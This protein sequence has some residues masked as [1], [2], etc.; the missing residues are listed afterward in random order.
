MSPTGKEQTTWTVTEESLQGRCESIYQ[1][2]QIPEYFIKENPELVPLPSKC[3]PNPRDRLYFEIIRT[4][5]LRSCQSL[6]Q[7][8]Y[9]KP[10]HINTMDNEESSTIVPSRTSVTRS[11]VCGSVTPRSS[12]ASGLTQTLKASGIVVQRILNENEQNENLMGFNTDN[13]VTGTKQ[14]LMIRNIEDSGSVPLI[15]HPMK[16]HDLMF[17]YDAKM[18]TFH[19]ARS[20][21]G[22]DEGLKIGRIGNSG[23]GLESEILSRIRPKDHLS[24]PYG[25]RSSR[26]SMDKN[27]QVKKLLTEVTEEI[28]KSEKSRVTEDANK[29]NINLKLLSAARG[30][31]MYARPQEIKQLWDEVGRLNSPSDNKAVMKNFFIDTVGMAG[32]PASI[33]FIADL[34]EGDEL[35]HGQIFNFLMWMPHNIIYPTTQLLEKLYYTV[36]SEKIQRHNTT[37]GNIAITSFTQLLQQACVSEERNIVYPTF[38]TGEFCN[39]NSRIVKN[40][41][42]P[43]LLGELA[44]ARNSNERNVY[45]VA[46]GALEHADSIRKL[47]PYVSGDLTTQVGQRVTTLN[48]LM[49]IYSLTNIGSLQPNI[50]I[51]SLMA[52]FSNPTEST[53]IRIAAFNCILKANPSTSVFERIASVTQEE[54]YIGYELLKTINIA[55]YTL[56]HE[57]PNEG[58]QAADIELIQKARV[59]FRMIRKV[60]GILPTTGTIYTTKFL[61]KLGVGYD[62]FISF[63]AS[64]TSVLP[65]SMYTEI[66]YVLDKISISPLRMG[67]RVSGSEHLYGK[68][69]EMQQFGFQYFQ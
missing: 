43:Y 20:G 40:K 68:L 22:F 15:S 37:L 49:A 28:I 47:L 35:T 9:Y 53:E 11:I 60:H 1:V 65:K 61:K 6:A 48:R 23:N 7:F 59:T 44:S 10:G 16:L 18:N 39:A 3:A 4:R 51:P 2:N 13:I 66:K 25:N 14:V 21:N 55:L 27:Y 45:L 57:L 69:G 54:P 38:V 8:N 5:N 42:I 26:S 19:T 46:L 52:V 64:E 12:T 32:T 17:E 67:Y 63:V 50:V 29:P 36:I 62:A 24:A 41:W 56:G 58:L 33:E 31:S 34:I 30:F